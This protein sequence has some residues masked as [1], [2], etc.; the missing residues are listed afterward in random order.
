MQN[1]WYLG[2][3]GGGTKTRCAL[4]NTAT[5]TLLTV[6]GGSTNHEALPGGM[7]ALHQIGILLHPIL[8]RADAVDDRRHFLK[9]FIRHH[10]VL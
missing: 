2:L 1:C 7:G 5:D 3:D 8:R 10:G 4:Y 9:A 6:R